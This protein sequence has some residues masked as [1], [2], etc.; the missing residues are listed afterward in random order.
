MYVESG[1]N[2][3]ALLT[4]LSTTT[5]GLVTKVA[6][7]TGNNVLTGSGTA[8]GWNGY[9]SYATDVNAFIMSSSKSLYS[10]IIECG[11]DSYVLSFYAS[12]TNFTV[13]IY[14]WTDDTTKAIISNTYLLDTYTSSDLNVD[15]TNTLS[16][17]TRYY[18]PLT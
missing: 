11:A 15:T 8:N 9:S 6:Q 18:T 2:V 13:K 10:P 4:T 12:N 3:S 16:Y 7:I 1:D 14:A 5:G 17:A